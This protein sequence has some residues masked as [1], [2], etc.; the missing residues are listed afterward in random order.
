MQLMAFIS[1]GDG[2]YP[3]L[4]AA[5]TGFM[6]WNT[7]DIID[8]KNSNAHLIV[9]DEST[10]GFGQVLPMLLTSS[11]GFQTID[12]WTAADAK[13]CCCQDVTRKRH[14]V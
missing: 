2:Y 12:A 6:A 1:F 11:I 10:W 14:S 13:P 5:S 8:L 9:G 7:Y 3:L 4:L